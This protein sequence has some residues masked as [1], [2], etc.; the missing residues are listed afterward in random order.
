MSSAFGHPTEPA[1]LPAQE[2]RATWK[3]SLGFS[4]GLL[5]VVAALPLAGAVA[6]GGGAGALLGIISA[7]LAWLTWWVSR[8]LRGS[9]AV[10][11]FGPEGI[12]GNCPGAFNIPWQQVADVR[13]LTVQGHAQIVIR[14]LPQPGEAVKR[15]W[16]GGAG[17]QDKHVALSGL[18]AKLH[19]EV[20]AAA[21]RQFE[22]YGG[23]RAVQAASELEA[24]VKADTAF[25]E[26]LVALTPRVWAMPA[27]MLLCVAVWVANVVSGMSMMQ[28]PADELFRW[29]ANS[30]SAVQAGQ[31]WRMVTAMFLHGGVLHL[32][33]NMYALW[34]AGLMVTRLFGNRGFLVVYFGAGLVGNALSLHFSGQTGVSVGASGAVF[35][36]AGALLAAVIQH[37]G[38]F[39]MGR[40]K[41]MLMSLGLFIF[42]SLAYGF[43]RQGIDNAAHVGGLLAGLVAGWLLVEKIDDSVTPA[44]RQVM[45]AAAALLCGAAT[46]ALVMFAPPAKRDVA[47]YF[48]DLKSWNALQKELT[49]A[50][51]A[52]R[53]DVDQNKAGKLDD[54]ALAS[55]FGTVHAPQLR[56]IA[57]G[58]DSLRLPAE[59]LTGKYAVAQGRYAGAAAAL[60]EADAQRVQA[61]SPEISEKVQRLAA[62]V[63]EANAAIVALDAQMDE[64]K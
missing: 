54:A 5:W 8:P 26:R 51:Q 44:R 4:A 23:T 11:R 40:S 41:Q 47:V 33:L 56:R 49:V 35:G 24:E 12:S 34:E 58:F 29:G 2:F 19:P 18:D 27:V 61:P 64:K 10:I 39:P 28:P 16:F 25:D 57:S 43:S 42:Y 59:E 17:R 20:V 60:M 32:A 1:A 37:R 63:R 14:R 31:W 3:S 21:Y 62:E 15:S 30:A 36:V 53:A 6:L 46:V 52:V 48:S 45:M 13:A 38:K 50:M 9:K 22:S 7:L 55:R